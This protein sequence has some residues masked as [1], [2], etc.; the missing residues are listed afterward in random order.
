L[1]LRQEGARPFLTHAFLKAMVDSGSA[2]DA[3]GWQPRW[4]T[5]HEPDGRIVGGCVLFDKHHSYGEY[6]FDWAWADAHDR[7]LSQHGMHYYPKLLSAVPF[8][9]IQGPRLLVHPD[10][11]AD[12]GQLAQT[13]LLAELEQAC[14]TEGRSSAHVL[15]L[16]ESQAQLAERRG[17]L[18]REGLQFH[19]RNRQPLPYADFDE[20]LASLQR[21]KR[22]KIL[23]DRRKVQEAGVGFRVLQGREISASDWAYFQRCYT[24]TY[25]QHGQHPYLTPAFWRSMHTELPEAWVLFLAERAGEPVACALLAV[26]WAHGVAYGRHWGA[27]THIPCLHFEACYH[28]PLAWC[29]AQGLQRFEGGAQGEHKLARGLVAS[30]TR[31][32]HW[33]QHPGLREAVARFLAQERDAVADHMVELDERKPFKPLPWPGTPDATMP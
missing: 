15:F 29:I 27:T 22:K 1:L 24:L 18:R 20:F 11:G 17:W 4:L 6:V 8:S 2:C 14:A 13:Q 30:G 25:H 3:T 19:W 9:P 33:L 23:Q 12:Q 32:V 21:D 28:Q 31:S 5:L 7:A 26:D 16:P 10:L